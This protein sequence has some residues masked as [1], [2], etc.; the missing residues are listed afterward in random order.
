MW[1][2]ANM[3]LREIRSEIHHA[4][5]SDIFL[6]SAT[7]TKSKYV[8]SNSEKHQTNQKVPP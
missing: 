7:A 1:E 5:E 8:I 6:Q 3:I 2:K 4:M